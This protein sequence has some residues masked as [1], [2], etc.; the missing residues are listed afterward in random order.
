MRKMSLIVTCEHAGNEVPQAFAY[1][2]P[3]QAVA[4]LKSHQGWD[5]G[6]L[7]LAEYL[8]AKLATPLFVYKFSR[9]LIEPN[10]SLYHP[11]LFSKYSAPLSDSVKRY[12][13]DVYYL[14][15]RQKVQRE[16]DRLIAQG[17]QVV[18]VSVHSFTP[19]Y[20]GVKRKVEVGLL[21]DEAR[22]NEVLF[23]Q[24]WKK[25]METLN[26]GLDIRNNEPYAGAD[27]GF[28]TYLRTQFPNE[29][30]LGLELE[31]SQKFVQTGLGAVQVLLR[32]SLEKVMKGS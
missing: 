29:C 19:D 18:H 11:Q 17:Q 20:F 4:D 24:D 14:P 21:F 3:Q 27:D 31:V 26:P 32:K 13:V 5:P 30:Y 28:T 10:R 23:C 1:L 15:Y 6:A 16:V 9:L 12:L 25:Q 7:E 22:E 2:F 8:A